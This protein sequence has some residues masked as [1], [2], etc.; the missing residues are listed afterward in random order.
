MSI[1][2]FC[3][4][5]VPPVLEAEESSI[6]LPPRQAELMSSL[7]P[8]VSCHDSVPVGP[9]TNEQDHVSSF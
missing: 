5:E 9:F 4:A 1:D 6:D 3:L 2:N 8:Q 7:T